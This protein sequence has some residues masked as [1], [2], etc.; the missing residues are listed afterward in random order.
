M[1]LASRCVLGVALFTA[2]ATIGC[3][4]ASEARS[5][6]DASRSTPDASRSTPEGP[7]GSSGCSGGA[8]SAG[9]LV[10]LA[11]SIES[12]TLLLAGGRLY[13]TLSSSVASV[14]IDGGQVTLFPAASGYNPYAIGGLDLFSIAGDQ[15]TGYAVSSAP[16]AGGPGN[17]L[18]TGP[19]GAASVLAVTADATDV[20]WSEEDSVLGMP[21]G[22]GAR[23]TFASGHG[24]AVV[25]LAIDAMDVYWLDAGA[26]GVDS[27]LLAVPRKGGTVTTLATHVETPTN[28]V[29]DG[30]DVFWG[31]SY[32]GT[33][34]S[35][36]RAG[37]VSTTLYT[38][39][40]AQAYISPTG[41]SDVELGGIAVDDASVYWTSAVCLR[42]VMKV[43]KKGGAALT[44]AT[45]QRGPQAITVDSTSAY[46]TTNGP[47]E[48][49]T[50]K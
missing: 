37:G 31:D 24:A 10:A 46:W 2:G 19:I 20:Y 23:V 5:T 50:P 11:P 33:I 44:L 27:T 35:V 16:L 1:S 48:K 40:T 7:D 8:A 4:S 25:E 38:D 9:S 42:S 26:R 49:L 22:G 12:S 47:L 29:S 41:T 28:V 3:S 39:M 14:A 30:T 43:A 13:W 34:V 17:T 21:S 15:A 18:A 45:G 32:S 36:P 6:L